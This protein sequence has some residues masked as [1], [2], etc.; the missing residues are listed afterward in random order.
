[1][2]WI[3]LRAVIGE[4]DDHGA[5]VGVELASGA[6]RWRRVA[7]DGSYASASDPRVLFH[8]GAGSTARAV[9][10]RWSDG[11]LETWEAPALGRYHL[12]RRGEGRAPAPDP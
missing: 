2:P 10:V 11:R 6:L 7:S 1:M 8:L 12:L 4:R 5:S 9:R 3:G